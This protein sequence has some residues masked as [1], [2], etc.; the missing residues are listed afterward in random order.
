MNTLVCGGTYFK[1]LK[2]CNTLFIIINYLRMHTSYNMYDVCMSC[3]HV[4]YYYIIIIIIKILKYKY[5]ILIN[6]KNLNV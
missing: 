3:S 5:Y 1:F 6:K 2:V 4:H